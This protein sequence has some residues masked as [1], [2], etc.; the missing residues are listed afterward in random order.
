MLS[1]VLAHQPNSGLVASN[2]G[3]SGVAEV[4]GQLFQRRSVDRC[5]LR[6]IS[7]S[8]SWPTLNCPKSNWLKLNILVVWWCVCGCVGVVCGQDLG[9][10]PDLPSAG[11]PLSDFF[12]PFVEFSSNVPP[13]VHTTARE[14][15]TCTFQGPG[16]F[17]VVWAKS[18]LPLTRQKTNEKHAH[19]TCA[20]TTKS[21]S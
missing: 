8:A 19:S 13:G 12:P 7:I 18:G 21:S 1:A 9:A 10:L 4:S 3:R 17:N 5:S 20:E 6:P 11:A 16:A 14:L 2:S 15:Q